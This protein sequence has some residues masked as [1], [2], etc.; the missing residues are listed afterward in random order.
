V[1][2]DH[3]GCDFDTTDEIVDEY[4]GKMVTQ[5][6]DMRGC[7]PHLDACPE[8]DLQALIEQLD[9][10][11]REN[12]DGN[13]D[14]EIMIGEKFVVKKIPLKEVFGVRASVLKHLAVASSVADADKFASLITPICMMATLRHITGFEVVQDSEEPS[15]YVELSE[16]QQAASPTAKSGKKTGYEKPT[17]SDNEY[18]LV[19]R[20]AS[21]STGDEKAL[22]RAGTLQNEETHEVLHFDLKGPRHKDLKSWLSRNGEVKDSGFKTAFQHCL[23][24]GCPHLRDKHLS[25]GKLLEQDSQLLESMLVSDY[26]V[27]IEMHAVSDDVS[28]VTTVEQCGA[29]GRFPTVFHA[30]DPDTEK[31]YIV[32]F[33]LI[34]FANRHIPSVLK[35]R[36]GSTVQKP[37]TY[38][39][40]FQEM[41]GNK[42]SA[43]FKP[44]VSDPIQLQTERV[45]TWPDLGEK[46]PH[47]DKR[48]RRYEEASHVLDTV[49]HEG[50]SE[51]AAP[52][53]PK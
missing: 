25:L 34:D 32:T 19:M 23:Y 24:V 2:A 45:L 1:K 44:W 5:L 41:Y 29:A 43:Y 49:Q 46:D 14:S 37:E 31:T 52:V 26:S 15:F 50:E 35:R 47:R 4:R 39:T 20:R 3:S 30:R 33:G 28:G 40:W 7:F 8:E 16:E 38:S 42:E 36:F 48:Q 27:Y 18:W 9:G 10:S 6:A 51:Q 22:I 13:S 21:M 17:Y 11:L 53:K 12:T